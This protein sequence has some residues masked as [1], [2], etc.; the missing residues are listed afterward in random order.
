MSWRDV[1][2]QLSPE[3]RLV[4]EEIRANQRRGNM[5]AVLMVV[6]AVGNSAFWLWWLAGSPLR[7]SERQ[8]G[9]AG[10]VDVIRHRDGYWYW[11]IP[12]YAI[13]LVDGEPT[14]VRFVPVDGGEEFEAGLLV[15]PRVGGSS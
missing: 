1:R 9:P 10:A 14:R 12:L 5:L 6:V 8:A 7:P 4:A 11:A 15:F 2:D 13:P 3:E